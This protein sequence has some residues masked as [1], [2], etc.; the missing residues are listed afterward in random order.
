MKYNEVW[1]AVDKLAQINGLTPSGLAKKAGLDPTIFNKS[2]RMRPDGKKRWPSLDSIN[3]ITSVCHI[4]FED[5]YHLLD[6][7]GDTNGIRGQFLMPVLNL[8]DFENDSLPKKNVAYINFPDLDT[9]MF[10]VLVDHPLQNKIYPLRSVLIVSPQ[11][12]IKKGNKLLIALKSDKNNKIIGEFINRTVDELK[13]LD[14][15]LNKKVTVKIDDIEKIG[16]I[17]WVSQ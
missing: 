4:T 1:D 7:T 9:D 16:R 12:K 13:I 17:M 11:A 6:E 14:I 8:S 5:F 3:K 10:A 15:S 2:K